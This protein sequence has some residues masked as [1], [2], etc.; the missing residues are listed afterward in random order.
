MGQWVFGS[1]KCLVQNHGKDLEQN[2][3]SA[4]VISMPPRS[5]PVLIWDVKPMTQ[6]CAK[7]VKMIYLLDRAYQRLTHTQ[8]PSIYWQQ[9]RLVTA[10]KS[11]CH[12]TN[13]LNSKY[14]LVS[15]LHSI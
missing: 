3:I 11:K 8:N 10:N 12:R 4:G 9:I 13:L 2:T 15:H 1:G 6:L 14:F 5:L 7:F